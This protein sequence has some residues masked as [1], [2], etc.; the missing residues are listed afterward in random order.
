VALSPLRVPVLP[1]RVALPVEPPWGQ[2]VA[3]MAALMVALLRV[4][5]VPVAL[6]VAVSVQV[7]CPGTP[8]EVPDR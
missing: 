2:R 7:R 1:A 6:R 3:L 4:P 8:D 5:A